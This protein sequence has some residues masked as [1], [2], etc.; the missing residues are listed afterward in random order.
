[1]TS[2]SKILLS[3]ILIGIADV[4]FSHAMRSITL[5]AREN[6]HDLWEVT[7]Y[8][9]VDSRSI[10]IVFPCEHKQ[11][12]QDTMVSRY[13]MKCSS[14][15]SRTK[16]FE[17]NGFGDVITEA[18]INVSPLQDKEFSGVMTRDQP[19]FLFAKR[20]DLQVLQDFLGFGFEHV[21]FGWDHL[22]FLLGLV[23]LIGRLQKLLILAT[24]FTL[25]HAL[26]I[27]MIYSDLIYLPSL[28]IEMGIALSIFAI[29]CEVAKGRLKNPYATCIGFGF[30]HGFGYGEALAEQQISADFSLLPL[31]GFNAGVELSQI[32]IV[33]CSYALIKKLQTI[34]GPIF[35]KGLAYL[36][37]SFGSLLFFSHVLGA[38]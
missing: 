14:A 32:V 1:M 17:I 13:E 25:A 11:I 36:I 35:S 21:V 26:S 29:G 28:L 22:V 23:A 38:I 19:R 31:L 24:C 6:V 7:V 33:C 15:N 34:F 16:F 37:G 3:L 20:T 12:F 18:I 5:H 9:T 30:I 27:G 2:R 10:E 4:G 8:K